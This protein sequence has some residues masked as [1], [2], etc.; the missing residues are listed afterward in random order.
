MSLSSAKSRARR[1]PLAAA[2]LAA[3]LV[4]LGWAGLAPL[5]AASHEATYEIPRGTF[6][7]RMHGE[8]V[9]IFPQT[10]R[11]TLGLNDV[12][13]LRNGDSVP[14]L[15]GPTIIMPG[16]SFRLPFETASTYSFECTAHPNG[17]LHVIVDPAPAPG[18]G[19]LQ[20]RWRE[21]T[22]AA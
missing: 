16:Q 5:R 3:A 12:L 17:G 14:H 11:L 22:G 13:V 6:A 4:G 9:D 1:Q 20:W 8:H 21:L 15:F 18:W 7:H 19:R 2:L 10:I